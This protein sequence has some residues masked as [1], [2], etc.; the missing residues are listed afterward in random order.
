MFKFD[1]CW[2]MRK[3][4]I[5]PSGQKTIISYVEEAESIK[6]IYGYEEYGFPL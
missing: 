6:R 1:S 3:C 5:R 2:F 4:L